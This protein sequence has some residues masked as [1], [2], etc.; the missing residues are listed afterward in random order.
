[1][2]AASG[3]AAPADGNRTSTIPSRKTAA[4]PGETR[5]AT[6]RPPQRPRA[7]I[8]PSAV[9]RRKKPGR[10]AS[11]RNDASD[12]N[13][14]GFSTY[15]PPSSGQKTSPFAQSLHASA[16]FAIWCGEDFA[17]P[18]DSDFAAPGTRRPPSTT[19]SR[20]ETVRG[21]V[22]YAKFASFGHTGMHL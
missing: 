15:G 12:E 6:S 19:S 17:P 11:E 16:Q 1:M 21:A 22:S 2:R 4:P 10:G 5:R 7:A 18:R 9:R 20:K 8:E 14:R 3:A 13:S